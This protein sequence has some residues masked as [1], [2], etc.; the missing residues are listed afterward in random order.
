M[1]QPRVKRKRN[2][3]PDEEA[4]KRPRYYDAAVAGEIILD[5]QVRCHKCDL[6]ESKCESKCDKC[7]DCSIYDNLIT[8]KCEES[9][10]LCMICNKL[11]T[12]KSRR[13]TSCLFGHGSTDDNAEEV[14]D[15]IV[16]VSKI[17]YENDEKSAYHIAIQLSK[18]DSQ[19]L[20]QDYLAFYGEYLTPLLNGYLNTDA[21]GP[22][23]VSCRMIVKL[24]RLM[25]D[26]THDYV[27]SNLKTDSYYVN[28]LDGGI[29]KD[30]WFYFL[31]TINKKFNVN[32]HAG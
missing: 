27:Y 30:A 23:K 16:K 21:P 25:P 26:D 13:C 8:H 32:A 1:N 17:T 11:I 22:V 6:A 20:P 28:P 19:L 7:P 12:S 29:D 15:E 10:C 18:E 14:K 9:L 24:Q 2:E 31:K 5:D 4:P 3:P